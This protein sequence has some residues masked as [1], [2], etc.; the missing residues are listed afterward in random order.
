MKKF[1]Q[2]EALLYILCVLQTL[3]QNTEPVLDDSGD[4]ESAGTQTPG[5]TRRD[6]KGSG[7][8]IS[9]YFPF[10]LL[11]ICFKPMWL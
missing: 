11:S 9:S 10:V 8:V 1:L 4:K 2:S 7:L 5:H 6:D 3:K